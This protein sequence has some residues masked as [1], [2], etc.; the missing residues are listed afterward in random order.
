MNKQRGFTLIELLV[1]IAI[2]AL[3]MAILMPALQRVRKQA[4]GVACQANLHQWSL[5]WKMYCDDNNG[6]WLSGAVNGTTSGY[7]SGRWWFLPIMELYE[8]EPDIRCCPEA[9]KPSGQGNIGSWAQHAWQTEEYIGSY[10]PNGWMCN[11]SANR[12]G[13]WGRN[14]RSDYW[15]TPNVQGAYN[16]PMFT[17]MWWVDSW[18]RHT[19]PPADYTGGSLG[20]H[21]TANVDEMQRV[22]V[23][24]HDG[25]QSSLFCDWSVRKV[26]LKELWTMKWNRSFN[27]NGPWTKA[28][29]VAPEDWPRWISRFKD[30]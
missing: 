16:I 1:V 5:I 11:L 2:I 3:L 7:G 27:I 4:R 30:Y 13:I 15:R 17:G 26:G 10:G 14:G 21:G 8:A 24:R 12:D 23:D 19:D 25:F 18:P 9:T 20:I 28:G 22:C 6:Y 29:G